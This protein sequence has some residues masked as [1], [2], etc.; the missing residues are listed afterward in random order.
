[1]IPSIVVFHM[2][3]KGGKPSAI[4]IYE[5]QTRVILIRLLGVKKTPFWGRFSCFIPGESDYDWLQ[6]GLCLDIHKLH[7]FGAIYML[8]DKNMQF[9]F[10]ILDKFFQHGQRWDRPWANNDWKNVFHIILFETKEY[11]V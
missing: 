6:T 5:E 9:S 3:R 7:F 2:L 11:V 10:R 1:M 8:S 4:E